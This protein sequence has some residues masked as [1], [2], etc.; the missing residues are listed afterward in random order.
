MTLLIAILLVFGLAGAGVGWTV[1]TR[2]L[3]ERTYDPML[4]VVPS[5]TLVKA[6]LRRRKSRRV[7]LT[8]FYALLGVLTGI[9]FLMY[10]ARR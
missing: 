3:H 4:P 2:T 1:G 8:L 7:L 5:R 9:A 6:E 10:L